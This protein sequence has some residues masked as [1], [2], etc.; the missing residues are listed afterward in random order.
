M[1]EAFRKWLGS[2]S[3]KERLGILESFGFGST[4]QVHLKIPNKSAAQEVMIDAAFR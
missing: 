4:V 1:H 2:T 3:F